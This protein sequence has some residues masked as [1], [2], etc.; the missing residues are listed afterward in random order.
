VETDE[1]NQRQRSNF[2]ADEPVAGEPVAGRSDA[3][4]S[5]DVANPPPGVSVWPASR[6][7]QPPQG[8]S[9]A[10]RRARA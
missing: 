8:A 3:D 2:E 5:L 6:Q 9:R 4:V 1:W 7:P 10:S